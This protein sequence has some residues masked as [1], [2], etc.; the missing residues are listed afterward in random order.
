MSKNKVQITQ[1]LSPKIPV[2]YSLMERLSLEITFMTKV[3]DDFKDSLVATCK[4]T[5]SCL[6][7]QS[8]QG[9][10]SHSRSI[11]SYR[12]MYFGPIK[13]MIIYRIRIQIMYSLHSLSYELPV[14][15]N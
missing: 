14:E 2:D 13:P 5:I 11:D 10:K 8:N 6:Q 7:Y 4:I 15:N 1:I 9:Q 12:C 3:F